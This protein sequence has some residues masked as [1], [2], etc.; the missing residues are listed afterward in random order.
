MKNFAWADLARLVKKP[1]RFSDVF[2]TWLSKVWSTCPISIN[3]G[4]RWYTCLIS[5]IMRWQISIWLGVTRIFQRK[6]GF[7]REVGFLQSSSP[8]AKTL[9]Q[10][11]S[12]GNLTIGVSSYKILSR[13]VDCSIDNSWKRKGDIFFLQL[14]NAVFLQLLLSATIVEKRF[15]EVTCVVIYRVLRKLLNISVSKS[16]FLEIL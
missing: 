11:L 7:C 4:I 6:R 8:Q 14:L 10:T 5:M 15:F 1:P 16:N 9:T 3:S 12:N 2:Q 13:E